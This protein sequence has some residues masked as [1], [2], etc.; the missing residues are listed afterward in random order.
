[1]TMNSDVFARE[2]AYQVALSIG[3]QMRNKAIIDD[4]EFAEM[5][6]LLLVNCKPV[7]GAFYATT[8]KLPLDK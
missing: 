4:V 6:D 5:S 7:I 2:L 3:V 8:S 1:M